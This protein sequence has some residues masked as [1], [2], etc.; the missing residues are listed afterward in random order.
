MIKN[1]WGKKLF[2]LLAVGMI[3]LAGC[4][5]SAGTESINYHT[6][7]ETDVKMLEELNAMMAADNEKWWPE[8]H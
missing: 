8:Y 6:L 7:P 4:V 2:C 5:S 1:F 3:L